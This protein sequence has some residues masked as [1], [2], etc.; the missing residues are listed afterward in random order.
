MPDDDRS[1]A[2][3]D[4]RQDVRRDCSVMTEITVEGSVYTGTIRNQSRGGLYVQS[5]GPF[6][7]GQDVTVVYTSPTGFDLKQTGKIVNLLPGGIGVKF[8]WPGYNR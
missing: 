4:R 5:R 1:S 8:N 7:E 6:S 2:G 3:E